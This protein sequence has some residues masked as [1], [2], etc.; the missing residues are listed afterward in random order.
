MSGINP[1]LS[2]D[3]DGDTSS[4]QMLDRSLRPT[5]LAD[6]IG[7]PNTRDQLDIFIKAARQRNEALD[8]VLVFGPPGLGKTTLANISTR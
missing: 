6:F 2:P 8:H 4:E 1:L 5:R 7:Q 3:V